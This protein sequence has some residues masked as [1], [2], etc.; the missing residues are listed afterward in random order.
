MKHQHI[1]F[2]IWSMA[3]MLLTFN[4]CLLAIDWEFTNTVVYKFM[5]VINGIMLGLTIN[6]WSNS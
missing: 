4:V 3:L 2:M 5:L 6:E 1:V